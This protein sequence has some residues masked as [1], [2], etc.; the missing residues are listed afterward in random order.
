M[1]L[2]TLKNGMRDGQ[3]VVVSRDLTLCVAVPDIASTLQQALDNWDSVVD[4]LQDVY[5]ALN[6][7]TITARCLMLNTVYRHYLEPIIGRMVP[8]TLTMLNWCAK[9]VAQKCPPV[10][11]PIL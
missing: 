8:L 5:F 4:S 1:K 6:E 2:A 3:L 9:R 10:S 7:R 11:G